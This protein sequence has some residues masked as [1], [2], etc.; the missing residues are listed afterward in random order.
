MCNIVIGRL[1]RVIAPLGVYDNTIALLCQVMKRSGEF[2]NIRL[3]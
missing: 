3:M 2:R 1:R